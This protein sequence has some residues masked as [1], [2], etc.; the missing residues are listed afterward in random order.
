MKYHCK[1]CIACIQRIGSNVDFYCKFDSTKSQL[2]KTLGFDVTAK[3][4][5]DRFVPSEYIEAINY[6]TR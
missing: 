5:C 1:D 2:G 4:P 6:D 3:T